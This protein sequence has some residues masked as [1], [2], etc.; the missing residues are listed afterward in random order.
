M[1]PQ[2]QQSNSLNN[3]NDAIQAANEQVKQGYPPNQ[4]YSP[5]KGYPPNQGY[6]IAQPIGQQIPTV[7]YYQVPPPPRQQVV[8]QLP[9]FIRPGHRN[10]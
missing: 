3:Q 5:N 1:V 10:Y 2:T 6:V 9:T 7:Q 8:V 4:A